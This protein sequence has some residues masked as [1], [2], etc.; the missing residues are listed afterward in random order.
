[1]A[2]DYYESTI[3]LPD[4]TASGTVKALAGVRVSVVP[5]GASDVVNSVV[6]IFQ[7]DVGVAQGPDPKSG[8]TGTNP[9]TTG[10][11]GSVRFWA[12]GPTEYDLVFEDT[13]VPARVADRFGWNSVPAKTGSM[14]TTFLAGDG[15]ISHAM[16]SPVVVRQ[17]VPIGGIIEWWRPSAGVPVPDGYEVCDGHSVPAGSHEFVGV[18]GAIN[19]PDLRNVFILGADANVADGTQP[20]QGVGSANAPGIRAG[21]GSNAIKNL[22][23][24]HGVPLPNHYH[25]LTAPNHRHGPGGLY[26]GNHSHAIGTSDGSNSTAL[27]AGQ[28]GGSPVSRTGHTH[29]GGTDVAGNIGVGGNT[30][31]SV[32]ALSGNTN[33]LA[34]DGSTGALSTATGAGTWTEVGDVR[35]MRPAYIGLLRIMKVRRA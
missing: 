25:L 21:G 6:P 35:D 11:S 2:R 14:P 18:S 29:G 30:D 24:T 28:S 22:A 4:A 15:G 16:L 34:A 32:D 5:R 8:A 31:Y 3:A 1:V 27:V 26:T 10:T 33:Y 23:H 9:F 7:A 20:A 19:M 13:I 17:E 12:D